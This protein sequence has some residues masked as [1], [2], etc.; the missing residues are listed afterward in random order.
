MVVGTM[1]SRVSTVVITASFSDRISASEKPAW[2]T[3]WP[4][5]DTPAKRSAAYSGIRK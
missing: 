3:T 4:K 2:C 1:S 5:L